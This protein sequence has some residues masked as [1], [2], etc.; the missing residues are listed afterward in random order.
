MLQTLLVHLEVADLL[1]TTPHVHT[2]SPKVQKT[3][4]VVLKWVV[5]PNATAPSSLHIFSDFA[6]GKVFQE[7]IYHVSAETPVLN[8][9]F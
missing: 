3:V 9:M 2:L 1:N 8:V 5:C 4:W 6:Q 7:H